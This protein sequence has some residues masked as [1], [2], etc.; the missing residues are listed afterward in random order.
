M[1]TLRRGL[2]GLL[3]DSPLVF[4]LSSFCDASPCLARLTPMASTSSSF[5]FPFDVS[6]VDFS[7]LPLS[8]R[9]MTLT[10]WLLAVMVVSGVEAE[11]ALQEGVEQ[12][13]LEIE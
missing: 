2:G 4:I 1:S 7:T 12:V 13:V 3:L 9:L 6:L 8:S 10:A 11:C 5:P